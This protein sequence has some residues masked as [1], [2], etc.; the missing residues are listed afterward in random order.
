MKKT[1]F[2]IAF[3]ISIIGFSQKKTD[4]LA[5]MPEGTTLTLKKDYIIPADSSL[6]MLNAKGGQQE[7]G[8]F[9]DIHLMIKSKHNWRVIKKGTQFTVE[10]FVYLNNNNA[11]KFLLNRKD[12][13]LYISNLIRPMNLKIDIIDDYFE[14]VFPPMEIYGTD[15]YIAPRDTIIISPLM[16]GEIDSLNTIN[17]KVIKK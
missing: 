8:S 15:E 5:M 2:L 10:G 17:K 16:P 6:I 1:L 11:Y 3:S 9:G 4:A 12:I 7:G 14:I 13:F